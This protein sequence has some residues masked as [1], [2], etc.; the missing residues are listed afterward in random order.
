MRLARR[1][2][3][4]AAA[5]LAPLLLAAA[6]AE[7]RG[8]RDAMRVIVEDLRVLVTLSV[9]EGALDD[10]ANENLILAATREIEEQASIVSEHAAREDT[11]VLAGFLDRQA[12]WMRRSFEWGRTHAVR[13]LLYDTVDVCIACHTRLSSPSDSPVARDF[14]STEA[15]AGLPALERARL[16]IATRRFRDALD[17]LEGLLASPRLDD[18]DRERAMSLYLRVALR[19]TGSADRAAQALAALSKRDDVDAQTR[20]VAAEWAGAIRAS[21]T[22]AHEGDEL[23]AA[24]ELVGAA[25]A[26]D[27][28]GEGSP[29]PYIIATGLLH[30]YLERPEPRD[31]SRSEAYYLLGFSENRAGTSRWLPQVELYLEESIRLAPQG[32]PAARS[33]ALLRDKLGEQFEGDLPEEVEL[34][35]RMLE[36]EIEGAGG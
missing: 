36:A 33:M 13:E 6:V 8:I 23:A 30:R 4:V 12:W 34:H 1:H 27:A 18:A 32:E 19:V 17:T 14:L 35:L 10:P 29:V 16:Q 21:D 15:L 2:G 28:A 7:E 11:G 26:R 3:V 5:L 25:T 24:R 31:D 9:E 22:R 20:A